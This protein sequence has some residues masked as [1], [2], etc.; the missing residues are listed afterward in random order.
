MASHVKTAAPQFMCIICVCE[1]LPWEQTDSPGE[2][3]CMALTVVSC[4]TDV[5]SH[6]P[7][8]VTLHYFD[9]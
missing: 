9:K 6:S 2:E 1:C 7:K 3:E 8:A 4:A 5:Y